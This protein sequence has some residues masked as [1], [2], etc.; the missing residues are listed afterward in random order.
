MCKERIASGFLIPSP[1]PL[2]LFGLE[3]VGIREAVG[4]P[5]SAEQDESS[6]CF[7][8]MSQRALP[9]V[10]AEVFAATECCGFIE[11]GIGQGVHGFG[12][13]VSV[14]E[15][16]GLP[17]VMAHVEM[18]PIG[19]GLVRLQRAVVS[20]DFSQSLLSFH[21]QLST[22]NFRL[23]SLSTFNFNL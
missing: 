9:V 19:N 14:V 16:N 6:R 7:E 4:A 13:I 12:L 17:A 2:F 23:I 22:F 3:G 10:V 11:F 15:Q 8:E 5:V 21:F 1:R 18:F 20:M